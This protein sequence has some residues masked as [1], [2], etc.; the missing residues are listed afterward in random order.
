MQLKTSIKRN[1]TLQ[2]VALSPQTAE[3][4]ACQSSSIQIPELTGWCADRPHNNPQP[5][6]PAQ[7]L[8]I[9][10]WYSSWTNYSNR[11]SMSCRLP[12]VPPKFQRYHSVS[13]FLILGFDLRPFE[14][15]NQVKKNIVIG[16]VGGYW[17][18]RV[19]VW[20]IRPS[21]VGLG[22]IRIIERKDLPPSFIFMNP[23]EPIAHLQLGKT[24]YKHLPAGIDKWSWGCAA[25]CDH[26]SGA[27]DFNF[28]PHRG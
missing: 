22:L 16:G 9:I 23:I 14:G 5:K 28:T 2:D 10:L 26:T 8:R 13:L 6:N 21:T 17:I 11:T 4:F 15:A 3:S 7:A 20:I 12:P 1:E 24:I 27:N 18:T 25:L 19:W